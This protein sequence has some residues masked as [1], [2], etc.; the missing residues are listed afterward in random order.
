MAT[1][2]WPTRDGTV[3]AFSSRMR[4][5][6]GSQQARLDMLV[7]WFCQG[8]ET[9]PGRRPFE[10]VCGSRCPKAECVFLVDVDCFIPGQVENGG[11]AEDKSAYPD[12]VCT[13]VEAAKEGD[14]VSMANGYRMFNQPGGWGYQSR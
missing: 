1:V 10:I 5:V 9:H 13:W 7:A 6:A 4:G 11:L 8:Q 12:A 2:A 3:G 14:S